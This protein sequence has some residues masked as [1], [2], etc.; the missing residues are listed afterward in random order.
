MQPEKLETRDLDELA[1]VCEA[2]EPTLKEVLN[3]ARD[4][5]VFAWE[6]NRIDHH[7]RVV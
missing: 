4:L 2:V 7:E 3:P 1:S 6:F 5:T